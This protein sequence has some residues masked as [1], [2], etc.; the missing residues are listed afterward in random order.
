[1]RTFTEE[2]F[3][4]KIK[5]KLIEYDGEV[6]PRTYLT[7]ERGIHSV[8]YKGKPTDVLIQGTWFPD[9]P[10]LALDTE[11]EELM[12]DEIGQHH[13]GREIGFSN[14]ERC[15]RTWQDAYYDRDL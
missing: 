3:Q 9:M 8:R 5:S 15:P 4:K 1:M 14:S 6:K 2:E 12:Q 11:V 13:I 10:L 7:G